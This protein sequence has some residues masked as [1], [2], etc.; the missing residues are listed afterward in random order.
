MLLICIPSGILTGRSE[1][2]DGGEDGDMRVENPVLTASNSHRILV[3]I[4]ESPSISPEFRRGDPWIWLVGNYLQQMLSEKDRNAMS[5][6]ERLPDG[7]E[8]Y[9]TKGNRNFDSLHHPDYIH[10]D[11][12]FFSQQYISVSSKKIWFRTT[13]RS[14]L[15]ITGRILWT[16]RS[17]EIRIVTNVFGNG[18]D[19]VGRL[20]TFKP[21]ET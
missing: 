20:N 18:N 12:T 1:G 13:R 5:L 9:L 8:M 11:A 10:P 6:F 7:N 14:L 21:S 2:D 3:V 17:W 15:E 19:V 4:P 16:A